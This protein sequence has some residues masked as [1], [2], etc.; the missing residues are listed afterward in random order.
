M[1]SEGKGLA[2]RGVDRLPQATRTGTYGYTE[3]ARTRVASI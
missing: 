2:L 3:I 1:T